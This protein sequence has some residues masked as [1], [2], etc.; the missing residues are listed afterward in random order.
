[1]RTSELQPLVVADVGEHAASFGLRWLRT[2]QTHRGKP[3]RGKK[4]I[5]LLYILIDQDFEDW[6]E[7]E[8]IT[9]TPPALWR[10]GLGVHRPE[11]GVDRPVL[12]FLFSDSPVKQTVPSTKFLGPR[13]RRLMRRQTWL[14]CRLHHESA[15][16]QH[17]LQSPR[18]NLLMRRRVDEWYQFSLCV[19]KRAV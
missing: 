9:K 10:H 12:K 16:R 5:G 15:T 1:M 8:P 14:G 4:L 19:L 17:C 11:L 7:T 2:K 6:L 18:Q 13:H 3:S